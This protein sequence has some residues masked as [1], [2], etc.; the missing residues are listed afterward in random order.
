VSEGGYVTQT[1]R[2]ATVQKINPLKVDFSIPERYA[3]QVSIGD[4]VNLSIEETSM[5]FIGRL[6]A[7]EPRIDQQLGTLQLRALFDNKSERVF[8]GAFVNIELQLKRIPDALMVPTQA[9]IPV[10]K[11]QTL[12]VLKRGKVQ[13]VPVQLG[14]RTATNVQITSGLA[15]GD[16]VITTG[17]MQLRAGMPVTVDIQKQ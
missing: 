17:L 12:L 1:T 15:P 2:I 10:L 14:V 7:I 5:K 4:R 13:S 6:Y 8:P 3:N 9:I 11:G 16:T